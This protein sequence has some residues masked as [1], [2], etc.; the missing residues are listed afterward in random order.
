MRALGVALLTSALIAHSAALQRQ[1]I[2]LH[3][4]VVEATI[5]ETK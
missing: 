1:N 5:F 2:E 4:Y 3:A